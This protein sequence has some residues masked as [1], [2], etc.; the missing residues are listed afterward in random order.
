MDLRAGTCV[1]DLW[2][3]CRWWG[4][5]YEPLESMEIIDGTVDDASGQTRKVLQDGQHYATKRIRAT[6]RQKWDVSRFPLDTQRIL[7]QLEDSAVEADKIIYVPD[8]ANSRL[9]PNLNV[10]G[11][12]LGA[13]DISTR[14]QV[15]D[16]NYGDTDLATGASSK[17]TRAV[18]SIDL[19]RPNMGLFWK[20][21]AGLFVAACIALLA[22]AIRP[23]DLDPR[24]GLPV[25]AM[26]A[27][28][29]SQYVIASV[30]PD[31][32]DFTLAD[33]LHVL[34]MCVILVALVES[35]VALHLIYAGKSQLA[36]RL[37]AAMLLFLV[38]GTVAAILILVLP[39]SG[40]PATA[41]LPPAR[42][43]ASL[44]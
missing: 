6:I 15:Y 22:T 24:F 23:T 26:F 16:T 1:A 5:E 31:S 36:R 9:S 20:L 13:F 34:V 8:K 27:T 3:W 43:A 7:I 38:V 32:A 25:G 35:V 44:N 18:L 40:K 12:V 21:F 41:I 33:Q 14:T 11:W 30:L 42:P 28:I 10:P 29:A 39:V 4:D 2:L 17:Y 19:H 37:D